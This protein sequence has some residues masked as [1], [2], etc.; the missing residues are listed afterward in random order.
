M[1][2]VSNDY[3]YKGAMIRTHIFRPDFPDKGFTSFKAT[4]LWAQQLVYWYN[5]INLHSE[6]NF[7]TPV[8]CQAGEYGAHIEIAINVYEA[9]KAKHPER[10]AQDTKLTY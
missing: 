6:L 2:R 8:K 5:E 4:R 7:V 9:A 10:W 3:P 1:A